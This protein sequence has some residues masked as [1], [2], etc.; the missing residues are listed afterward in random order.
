[1]SNELTYIL[2]AGASYQ[3]IPVVKTFP[4]RF[5][6]FASHIENLRFQEPN[7]YTSICH[8]VVAFANQINSHQS[9]DT[10]FKKLFHTKKND[11]ITS[12]KR[13]LNLYF[14]WEHLQHDY[15]TEF[16]KSSRLE[17][18]R[19]FSENDFEK[20]SKVDKRYD[21]LIAG[22]LQPQKGEAQVFC[23]TNFITWNY[24]LNL[25]LSLKNYFSPDL[26]IGEFKERISSSEFEWNIENQITVINMN[27]YF[28][29]KDFDDANDFD[30]DSGFEYKLKQKIY[31]GYFEPKVINEDAE[32]IKFAWESDTI[33]SSVAKSMIEKSNNIV[34]VGYTFP[35]YNRLVDFEYLSHE[36]IGKDKKI[37]IQDPN[38][39]SIRQNL[40]DLYEKNDS[41]FLKTK[42]VAIK[43]CDS[44]YVPA[45]IYGIDRSIKS[46]PIYLG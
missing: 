29:S 12:S 28:Y 46:I 44:F 30:C 20:R 35:L 36:D 7:I 15:E 45:N 3:S 18:R 31:S 6:E 17:N 2:G 26:T 9:F 13:I 38:S 27:G 33:N 1:M 25:F 24:D 8:E 32:L 41:E 34:V 40:L 43:D 21:A 4:S 37:I 23:K 22:L 42:L 19:E 14:L 10:Y 11:L 5:K 39:T 16:R